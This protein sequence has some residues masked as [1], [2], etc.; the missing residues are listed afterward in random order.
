MRK[1]QNS[2]SK[3]EKKDVSGGDSRKRIAKQRV[4]TAG[5]HRHRSEWY[6]FVTVT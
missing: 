1:R 2:G 5:L 6:G 4:R 3:S